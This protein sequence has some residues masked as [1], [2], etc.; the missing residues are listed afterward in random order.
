MLA[1][2]EATP[3]A[4]IPTPCYKRSVGIFVEWFGSNW[5]NLLQTTGIVAGL[6]FTGRSFLLDTRIRRIS[7]LLNITEHHRSIWQQVFEKPSLLRVLSEEPKL[8]AKPVT[9]EERVFV[10]LIILHLTAVL[11]AIRGK[12][13][14]Q[15]AGQDEDLR[16]F[17]SLPIPNKV[18]TDSKKFR[19]PEVVA[20]LDSLLEGKRKSRRKKARRKVLQ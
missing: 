7:N 19:E 12:V 8:D 17:F 10:N 14:E 1:S 11:T 13:H 2:V 16:E 4:L 5:F 15:P 20:Y 6:F 18:W 9:L 3:L